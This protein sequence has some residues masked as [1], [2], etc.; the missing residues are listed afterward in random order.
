MRRL[1]QMAEASAAIPHMSPLFLVRLAVVLLFQHVD[2][3]GIAAVI[4]Q[5]DGHPVPVQPRKLKRKAKRRAK[6]P[7]D[8]Q[9]TTGVDAKL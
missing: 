5:V 2:S 1:D 6:A 7:A 8:R 9:K 4:A 3:F